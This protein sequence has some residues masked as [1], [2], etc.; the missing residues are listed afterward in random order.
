MQPIKVTIL[1]KLLQNRQLNYLLSMG[2]IV[3]F[4]GI[5]GM[6]L[7]WYIFSSHETTITEIAISKTS[8]TLRSP[9]PTFT[10]IV[11]PT[12][13]PLPSATLTKKDNSPIATSTICA[14]DSTLEQVISSY[15][16]SGI[17]QGDEEKL[18][19]VLALLGEAK[20]I[21]PKTA[22]KWDELWQ[23]AAFALD[24]LQ[25]T[26]YLSLDDLGS[27]S[28]S[29]EQGQA[30]IQP[31]DMSIHDDHI[32]VIDSGVLYSARLPDIATG[33]NQKLVLSP[34]LTSATSIDGFPVK[35]IIAVDG[36]NIDH[37]I[38]VLDK[39]ND[40][41][42]FDPPS[43]T[44]SLHNPQARQLSRPDPHFLNI[45]TYANRLYLLDTSRNQI[46]RYPPS[47]LGA[48]YLDSN[49]PWLQSE[50]EPDVTSGIAM[51]ID[52]SIFLLK[53]EGKIQQYIPAL[54]NTYAMAIASHRTH[55]QTLEDRLSRPIDLFL[56][57]ESKHLFI[58]DPGRRRVVILNKEDGS[59]IRQ[60]IFAELS[61]FDS[62][63][64]LF[65]QDEVLYMLAGNHLYTYI[66]P[67]DN[68]DMNLQGAL[69]AF[70]STTWDLS[71]VTLEDVFPNDPRV[72]ALLAQYHLAL[73]TPGGVLPDQFVFYPGA[74]RAY[75]Y[76]VHQ[77]IDFYEQAQG[78]RME[79]GT[80]VLSAGDGVVVRADVNYQ[81]MSLDEV[82]FL[83]ADAHARHITPPE[84]LDK[85]GGRQVW[86]D[87]GGGLL[88]KYEHLSSITDGLSVGDHVERGQVI[89][90]VGLSG[91]PDGIEGN[92]A[93]PHLHFEIRIGPDH[94][95]YLGQWLSIEETRRILESLFP[96]ESQN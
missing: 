4:A 54:A 1:Q 38:Y 35:E 83:L 34:H 91:T 2:L 8:P 25:G 85:L 61:D 40:I 71:S 48:A 67:T 14:E 86:I 51:A 7:G 88:T 66:L 89:G 75:R 58:A 23:S 49:L 6:M 11:A 19:L 39:S 79:M 44:W 26:Y 9:Q 20:S 70:A 47:E 50:G 65:V 17:E 76:G 41:F 10:P 82:N 37:G 93:F 13:S 46:W 63:H 16:H 3:F 68:S 77:G 29:D 59:F 18:Q 90:K 84:T 43:D 94:A 80:P 33:T 42:F 53:R 78:V 69:P 45:T 87:H 81:E 30:L 32:Y 64:A 95:Y 27:I 5:L 21:D 72:P 12:P 74:R 36:E 92:L 56:S 60:F 57:P 52:G 62:L 22:R 24:T 15:Y 55:L 28:L 96:S 73:P 31:V